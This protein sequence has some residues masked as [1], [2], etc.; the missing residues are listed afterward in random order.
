MRMYQKIHQEHGTAYCVSR[1]QR[2]TK[3]MQAVK[4][5]STAPSCA[6]P[7]NENICLKLYNV[8]ITLYINIYH[9]IPQ[10]RRSILL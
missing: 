9:Y 7:N 8:M 4:E 2:M 6:L 3:E 10:P 5:A 1:D